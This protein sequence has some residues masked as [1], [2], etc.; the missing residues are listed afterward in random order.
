MSQE[1]KD[2]FG[3]F[4]QNYGIPKEN[5]VDL[6]NDGTF[7]Y[8]WFLF[9]NPHVTEWREPREGNTSSQSPCPNLGNRLVVCWGIMGWSLTVLCSASADRCLQARGR[10]GAQDFRWVMSD[11]EGLPRDRCLPTPL[12]GSVQILQ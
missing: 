10:H 7:I 3:E 2:R 8:L 11:G 9:L 4:C 1:L 6:T 12:G 5:I